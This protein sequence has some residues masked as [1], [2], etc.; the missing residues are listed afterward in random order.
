MNARIV[1]RVDVDKQVWDDF[2]LKSSEGWAYH[3]YDLICVDRYKEDKDISFAIWDDDK[4][5]IALICMLHIEESQKGVLLHSRYGMVMK[6]GLAPKEERKLIEAYKQYIDALCI[7]Y[8][9]KR[10]A[11]GTAPLIESLQPE[12]HELIN[13]LMKFGYG[14]S[15][16]T[17]TYTWIVNLN[18]T[19][20]ELVK[21]C[22]Q[23]TRQAIRKLTEGNRYEVVEAQNNEY[24]YQKYV[25]LHVATYTRTG[26]QNS[27]IHEEYQKNIFE[28]L[29]PQKIC[30]CFFLKERKTGEILASV[31]ILI[32][33]NSAYYW[34]GSSVDEKEVGINKFLLWQSMM[35]VKEDFYKENDCNTNFW[36]E[37]GG[38]YTYARDGKS[39][40][41]S[42]FKKS[43]GCTLHPIYRGEY[44]LP[45]YE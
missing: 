20:E 35:I 3:L 15:M 1:Q 41:L 43:F 2:V 21:N 13:P 9:V 45:L 12:K 10:L 26:A 40:G 30:R 11:A 37:T 24:D 27:I 22:E 23:T 25:E 44:I 8:K 7:R 36:F 34:W 38:A 4:D 14:P 29:I 39:K 32:Y 33:K 28:K 19:Q 16:V 5:E 42:S 17:P 18:D 6:D 31:A